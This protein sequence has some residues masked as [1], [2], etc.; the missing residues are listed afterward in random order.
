MDVKIV[1]TNNFDNVIRKRVGRTPLIRAKN[2]E[3]ELGVSEIYLK[4][5]GNNPSGHREDRL[6]YLIIRDALSRS[7]PV[8]SMGTLGTVGASLAYLAQFYDVKC[9]FYV[10]KRKKIIRGITESDKV[11]IRPFGRTYE[12]CVN[13]SRRVS[14]KYGWY[15]ANPGLANNM[16]NM[17][18]FSYVAEEIHEQIDSNVDTIFCQTSNGS[19]ISGLNLGLKHLWVS[20]EISKMPKIIAVSTSH[21]NAIVETYR[22]GVKNIMKLGQPDV[23]ESKYNQNVI[24][25][26][27]FNGQDAINAIHDS[28]GKA[29][30]ISDTDL[31][32]ATR[33]FRELEDIKLSIPNSYPVAAFMKEVELG[34]IKEGKHV[35]ILND[36]KVDIDIRNIKKSA[37]QVNYN[38]FLK[39]LDDWLIQFSD[40]IEEIR[41]AVDDAFNNGFVIC[42]YRG[43]QLVGICILST[44]K[45]EVF[46]PKYHLSYIATKRDIKGRG[47][48]TMLIQK[49]IELTGGDF[50]LHVDTDNKRAIRLYEKM[51]LTKKYYRMFYTGS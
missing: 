41:E 45:Y 33:K 8:I 12:E 49:A 28:L 25:T 27:S 17:Y 16:T 3:K 34:L 44:S 10:P 36:G 50:S 21:G 38:E 13:E 20:E 2:L 4:L 48:A 30:G 6:A 11:E 42:A 18:A 31:L 39:K 29:I 9:V 46:F 24:N 7:K 1:D 35:L 19:S 26:E 47:I 43:N 32:E 14:E 5:E 22:S 37:L 51:G 23:S 15:D 40:P